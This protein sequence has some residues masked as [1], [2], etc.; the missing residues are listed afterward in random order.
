MEIH[1][2]RDGAKY[3]PYAID[4]A[5][6][7][8]DSGQLLPS[9]LAWHEGLEEWTTLGELLAASAPPPGT[10]PPP[11]PA[12]GVAGAPKPKASK[13]TLISRIVLGVVL[14]VVGVVVGLDHMARSKFQSAQE[15]LDEVNES[16][17]LDHLTKELGREPESTETQGRQ[18]VDL[19]VWKGPL[20]IYSISVASTVNS[21]TKTMFVDDFTPKM[22]WRIGG[23]GDDSED[24]DDN[25]KSDNLDDFDF[26]EPKMPGG[27]P[28]GGPNG[29]P[30]GF[31]GGGPGPPGGFPGGGPPGG[32]GM[33]EPPPGG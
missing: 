29:P 9:D 31:P 6:G 14:L 16:V 17:P 12:D 4:D 18:T 3:G 22:K 7:L 1:I 32:G 10:A 2:T 20:R 30:G 15:F 24:S 11:V 8:L 26:G 33:P 28:G 23:G 5:R 13:A 27:G 25:G 21:G 19:F